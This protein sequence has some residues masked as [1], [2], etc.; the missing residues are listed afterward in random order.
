[1]ITPTLANDFLCVRNAIKKLRAT[2]KGID[3]K[4]NSEMKE[5]VEWEGHSRET[6]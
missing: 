4:A 2:Y 5:I 3:L 6:T 1:L